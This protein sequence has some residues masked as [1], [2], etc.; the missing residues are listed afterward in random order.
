MV[1]RLQGRYDLG[2]P[3]ERLEGGVWYRGVDAR[4]RRAIHAAV[5]EAEASPERVEALARVAKLAARVHHPGI[6]RVVT[7]GRDDEGRAFLIV[8][9]QG[10]ETLAAA[11]A[12]EPA[13]RLHE[14]LRAITSVLNGLDIAH[15]SGLV[16]GGIEPSRIRVDD[17]LRA[18]L[19][20]FGLHGV[21]LDADGGAAPYRAPEVL[22][23][24]AP[25]AASDV[26]SMAAIVHRAFVGEPPRGEGGPALR[27]R[28]KGLPVSLVEAVERGLSRSPGD[29]PSS[30]G[31]LRKEL[32][33]AMIGA[34]GLRTLLVWPSAELGAS[35]P[36]DVVE[37]L[38]LTDLE[39]PTARERKAW[40]KANS[41]APPPPPRA[42][43]RAPAARSHDN[44]FARREVGARARAAVALPS[45]SNSTANARAAARAP[46]VIAPAVVVGTPVVEPS[47]APAQPAR[48][49]LPELPAEA[50][51]AL[52]PEPP[53]AR[54]SLPELPAEALE[55]LE[56]EPPSPPVDSVVE[57]ERPAPPPAVE[58]LEAAP[59][60]GERRAGDDEALEPPLPWSEA[61]A[62][63]A[64]LEPWPYPTGGPPGLAPVEAPPPSAR[65]LR[66]R[67][68]IG[69]LAV[70][71][72]VAMIGL[73]RLAI[74]R[75]S[76][77]APEDA[78]LASTPSAAPDRVRPRRLP[79]A[80]APIEQAP[81]IEPAPAPEAEAVA[82]EA[83]VEAPVEAEA[84]EPEASAEPAPRAT[85]PRRR[86]APARPARPSSPS[87]DR[88]A[89]R[90][91]RDPGF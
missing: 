74:D 62:N 69:L 21:P 39:E 80:P 44:R 30:A 36:A 35:G 90:I 60:R 53:P 58:E 88:E 52:E 12:R 17:K 10:G 70:G 38:S 67:L 83:R 71:V 76:D 61:P 87:P 86:R 19:V 26:Y 54:P 85:H 46:V 1:A 73:V 79:R 37:R 91:V 59:L 57:G 50:L 7:S 3:I 65:A 6:E 68:A 40:A 2:E 48:P 25:S 51:E 82:V 63:A 43:A 32:T 9:W 49:S 56:P 13:Y 20:A 11:L 41:S 55:A 28:R 42:S 14:V 22:A 4:A 64:A 34:P 23:G 15:K 33:A 16:H 5:L 78:P 29:R 8:E 84:P 31:E 72:V 75:A 47:E 18:Q 45:P 89:P 27:E 77:D 81:P 66:P 24:E